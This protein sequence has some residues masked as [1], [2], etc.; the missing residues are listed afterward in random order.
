MFWLGTFVVLFSMFVYIWVLCLKRSLVKTWISVY[1]L[2]HNLTDY[3]IC[4][5]LFQNA[6]FPF[7]HDNLLHNN[8]R[9]YFNSKS[10]HRPE[11]HC[12]S[13]RLQVTSWV[14]ECSLQL[15]ILIFNSKKVWF[16]FAIHHLQWNVAT[17]WSKVSNILWV[18]TFLYTHMHN[19][20]M[21]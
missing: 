11:C 10:S 5:S 15:F 2:A 8:S 3:Y 21:I 6:W 13:R 20:D 17:I 4:W 14:V 18:Q 1:S 19:H 9:V 12:F 7:I 16:H